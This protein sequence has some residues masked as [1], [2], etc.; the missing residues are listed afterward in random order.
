MNVNYLKKK[1]DLG[2]EGDNHSFIDSLGSV[3]KHNT[4][5]LCWAKNVQNLNLFKTG[6]VICKEKDFKEIS[7]NKDVNYLLCNNPRLIFAK[8]V[9]N[10]F[11]ELLPDNF[12][13]YVDDH[14]KNNQ[15]KIGSNVFIGKDVKIG[16]GSVIHHNA[17][18]YSNSVIGKNCIIG[19]GVSI[20][21]FGLGLEKDPKTDQYVRF[22]QIGGVLL[23]DFVEVGP[24][25][26]IRRAALSDTVVGF[27][28]KIGSFCNVG[29]NC[30]IGENCILTSNVIIAGSSKIGND[31][32][33]GIS[34]SVKNAIIIG[35]NSKVGQGA[36]VIKNIP[37]NEV[38][39]GN[40]AKKINH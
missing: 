25:S 1:Y 30:I 12:T 35:D 28:S 9:N 23:G 20:G 39:I 3:S 29:H 21:T 14:S 15:I 2:F 18:I 26:T 40:P 13:N 22:P 7:H 38:W 32:Y 27:G 34:S 31:V 36:V 4:N 11:K 33:L 17:I 10:E 5:S 24:N 16:N 37:N 19:P 6:T 8:I